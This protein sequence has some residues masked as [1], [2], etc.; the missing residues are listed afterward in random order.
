MNIGADVGI[1]RSNFT[2]YSI[3]CRNSYSYIFGMM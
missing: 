1:I 3:T 2:Y